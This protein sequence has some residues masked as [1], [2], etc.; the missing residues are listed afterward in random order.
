M[1]NVVITHTCRGFFR[2]LSDGGCGAWTVGYKPAKNIRY[3]VCSQNLS[4]K[5]KGKDWGE[6]THKHN[7]IIM[8]GKVS[9]LVE[10]P[11]PEGE[12]TRYR[13][14]FSEYCDSVKLADMWFGGQFSVN[15]FTQD[16][17]RLSGIDFDNLDFK[18]MPTREEL[19]KTVTLDE[20]KTIVCDHLNIKKENLIITI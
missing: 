12:K 6:A 20:V 17:S 8:I 2:L 4:L 18:P 5:R 9:E 11:T 10:V 19:T 3:V 14:M 1:K 16:D 15:Y 7:E 13:F